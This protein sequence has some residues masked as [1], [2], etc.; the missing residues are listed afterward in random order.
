MKKIS[1]RA[2]EAAQSTAERMDEFA[3]VL[4]QQAIE[5]KVN[6]PLEPQIL[7]TKSAH[8]GFEE[9]DNRGKEQIGEERRTKGESL[10]VN[11]SGITAYH[12]RFRSARRGRHYKVFSYSA[13]S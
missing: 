12:L 9:G 7:Q 5:L 13:I 2:A 3:Q 8:T 11:G 4:K 10:E 6:N 1:E